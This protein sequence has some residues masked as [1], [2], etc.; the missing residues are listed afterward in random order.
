M[1]MKRILLEYIN[2]RFEVL[3]HKVNGIVKYQDIKEN[4]LIL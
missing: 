2:K 3:S 4:N 1:K